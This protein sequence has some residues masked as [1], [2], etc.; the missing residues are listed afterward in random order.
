M[1]VSKN[2]KLLIAAILTL[3]SFSAFGEESISALLSEYEDSMDLT[4]KTRIESLGHYT[5]FTRKDIEMMQANKLSDILKSLRLHTSTQSNFGVYQL[6]PAGIGAGVDTPYRL[7]INDHEVSSLHTD[8]PCLTYDNYPLDN[9]DHIEIYWGAG[10]VRVGNEPSAIIVKL[11]TKQPDRENASVF[12]TFASTT[13]DYGFSF[14]DARKPRENFSYLVSVYQGY[15][16]F[17]TQYLDNTALDRDDFRQHAFLQFNYYDTSVDISFSRVKKD[18]YMGL[19][20][21]RT[22]DLSKAI[23]EDAYISIT[24][25]LLDDKSLKLNFAYDENRKKGEFENNGLYLPALGFPYYMSVS[26]YYDNRDLKKYTFY[27]SKE[28][29]TDRDVLLIGSSVKF[30]RNDILD[31]YPTALRDKYKFKN[32]DLYTVFIENQ[33]NINEKNLLFTSLKYDHYERDGGL[34][35]L[36]KF[37]SRLGFISYINDNIYVKGFLMKSYIPPSLYEIENSKD[38]KNLK[39]ADGEGG[40][41]EL[42]YEKDKNKFQLLYGYAGMKNF[43]D[44]GQYGSYNSDKSMRSNM[45]AF[46]Y[47]RQIDA[48]KKFNFSAYKNFI[49]LTKLSPTFGWYVRYLQ[50]TDRF[51]FFGELIYR[52]GF[53]VSDGSKVSQSYNLDAGVAYHY[54]PSLSIKLKGEN[55]LNSSP[56]SVFPPTSSL[57]ASVFNSYDRKILITIEKV[58]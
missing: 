40:S 39:S 37:I 16:N 42:N 27:I 32:Q 38:P 22:P 54:S 36:N 1:A 46:D 6:V 12:K 11:Y 57:P 29:K 23:S 50:S 21:D 25:Y 35:E 53:T 47:E 19:A 3:N 20:L 34:G 9:I 5:V 44:F 2:K 48:D 49:N 18:A 24:Q 51:D 43:I 10:A 45:L 31:I 41:L 26:Y 8:N 58:F 52:E 33:F 15:N 17:K 4:N 30:K 13:K 55:L 14:V 7:F 56:K 28:F